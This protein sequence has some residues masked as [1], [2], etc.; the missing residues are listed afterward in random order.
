MA[1]EKISYDQLPFNNRQ[2]PNKKFAEKCV[3][4]FLRLDC[5]AVKISGWPIRR[6]I[7]TLRSTIEKAVKDR[8]MTARVKVHA[9]KD[10]VYMSR[11]R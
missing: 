1:L 6:G 7:S 10:F 3:E 2:N 11:V 5:D 9:D 4:D 8:A